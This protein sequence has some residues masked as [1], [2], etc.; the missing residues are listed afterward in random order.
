MEAAEHREQNWGGD[1]GGRYQQ[2]G[3]IQLEIHYKDIELLEVRGALNELF[4]FFSRIF[5]P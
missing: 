1:S 4:F 3:S 5:V 2:G